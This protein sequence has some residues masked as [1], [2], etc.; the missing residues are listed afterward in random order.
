MLHEVAKEAGVKKPVNPHAWRHSFATEMHRKDMNTVI[1][2]R[3][4]GHKGLKMLSEIYSHP[5]PSDLTKA[6][7]KALKRKE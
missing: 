7:M 2:Q 4:L 6:M 5:T 1:T 3:I